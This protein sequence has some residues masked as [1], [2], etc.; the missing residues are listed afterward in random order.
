M[1]GQDSVFPRVDNTIPKV[2]APL[3]APRTLCSNH[4]IGVPV[5][6]WDF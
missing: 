1:N 2:E 5:T 4:E 6:V 3:F